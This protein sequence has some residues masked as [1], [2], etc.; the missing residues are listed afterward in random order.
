MGSE[1]AHRWAQ[2]AENGFGFEF[3]LEIYHNVD[4]ELVTSYEYQLM[5]PG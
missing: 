5:T 3:F 4:G 2:N 1:N